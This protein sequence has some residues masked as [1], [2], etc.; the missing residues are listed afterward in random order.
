MAYRPHGILD[1]QGEGPPANSKAKDRTMEAV[2]RW[3]DIEV[4]AAFEHRLLIVEDDPELGAM[5]SEFLTEFGYHVEIE[6]RGDHAVRCGSLSRDPCRRAGMFSVLNLDPKRDAPT[7][8][9]TPIL[10]GPA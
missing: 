6:T 2:T 1:A 10:R 5:V 7:R 3:R 9:N 4:N 8:S